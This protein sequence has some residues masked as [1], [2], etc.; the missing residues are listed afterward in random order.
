MIY[1]LIRILCNARDILSNLIIELHSYNMDIPHRELFIQS[2]ILI[3][4]SHLRK[5]VYKYDQKQNN[6]D[7]ADISLR[8]QQLH[9][10][11]YGLC[12]TQEF[13]KCVLP[14]KRHCDHLSVIC[15]GFK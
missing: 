10:A 8:T 13:F 9:D 7:T 6:K 1:I 11:I 15:G 3:S 5:K 2:T 12:S 4:D 14:K